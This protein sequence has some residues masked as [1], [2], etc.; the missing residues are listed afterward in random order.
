MKKEVVGIIIFGFVLGLAVT[1]GIRT[2]NTSLKKVSMEE[3]KPAVPE[4]KTSE[5][6]KKELEISLV[7]PEDG[8]VSSQ[9]KID[10]T[11]KTGSKTI[12][13]V[14]Y[15]DGEKIVEADENGDFKTEITLIGGDNGIEVT[16]YNEE[17]DQAGQAISVIYSTAKIE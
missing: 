13:A 12:V 8:S 6:N 14:I 16:A 1:L 7:S 4:E 17:G 2:A 10:V 11:G 9:E 5:E 3:I 15:P